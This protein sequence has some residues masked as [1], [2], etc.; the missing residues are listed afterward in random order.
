MRKR[1]NIT[2]PWL[3]E[4]GSRTW[5]ARSAF[6]LPLILVLCIVPVALSAQP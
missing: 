2:M 3:H 1:P 4:G 6:A 5:V